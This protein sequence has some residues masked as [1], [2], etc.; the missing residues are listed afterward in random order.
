MPNQLFAYPYRRT[1]LLGVVL[2]GLVTMLLL[3]ALHSPAAPPLVTSVTGHAVAQRL[4]PAELPYRTNRYIF[5]LVRAP[6]ACP[7]AHAK[8]FV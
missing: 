3:R 4:M 7:A 5:Y 1:G 6:S 8:L 2:F